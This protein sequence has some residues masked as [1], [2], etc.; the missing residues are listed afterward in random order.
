MPIRR[1]FL[2][3]FNIGRLPLAPGTFGSLAAIPLGVGILAYSPATLF[4]SA[5]LVGAVAIKEINAYESESNS[6][7]ASEIVVDELVGMWLAMAMVGWNWLG[8]TLA[9]LF[10]RLF[11]IKKPSI[12]GRI[13]R[14]VGG[15]LGVVAD[16]VV[17]G[18]FGGLA[19]LL[20]LGVVQKFGIAL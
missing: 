13:D 19:A 1:L 18:F 11:D 6:H 14:E 8:I 16:D 5:L 9:F 12:I 3:L 2:T 15:G 4:L 10:F 17:A 20:V 7:D